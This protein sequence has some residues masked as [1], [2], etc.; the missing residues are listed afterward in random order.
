MSFFNTRALKRGR[1]FSAV[2]ITTL[3]GCTLFSD[4]SERTAKTQLG[5]V[6]FQ[7]MPQLNNRTPVA[8]DLIQVLDPKVLSVLSALKSA[9]WFGS[10]KDFMRQYSQQMIVKSWELVPAQHIP[11]LDIPNA[12][13][14]WVGTLI[15]ANYPGEHTY[16]AEIK[17]MDEVLIIL[18]D[19]D[20]EVVRWNK[21][22]LQP[23]NDREQ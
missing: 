5:K 15:F 1:Y 16:R 2:I 3:M 11:L 22:L 12:G 21:E 9:E 17:G 8:V 4:F 18:G 13:N 7:S 6:A 19:L 14:T 10:K 20:F 23:P